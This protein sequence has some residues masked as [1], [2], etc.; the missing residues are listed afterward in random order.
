M[1]YGCGYD[2]LYCEV[3]NTRLSETLVTDYLLTNVI[4]RGH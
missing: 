1:F 4:V 3:G 2:Y